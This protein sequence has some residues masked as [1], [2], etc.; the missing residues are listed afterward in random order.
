MSS[1]SLERQATETAQWPCGAVRNAVCVRSHV[2]VC[3][4]GFMAACIKPLAHECLCM[5]LYSCVGV[6]LSVEATGYLHWLNQIHLK[7]KYFVG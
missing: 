7:A 4:Y 2:F 1:V 5:C 3:V 6:H